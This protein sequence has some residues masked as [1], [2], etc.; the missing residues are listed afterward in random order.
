[1]QLHIKNKNVLIKKNIGQSNLTLNNE[2]IKI[3]LAMCPQVL[4]LNV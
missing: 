4:N 2:S 1:M 3:V